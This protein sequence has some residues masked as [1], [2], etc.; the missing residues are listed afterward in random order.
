ME[1]IYT[2][3]GGNADLLLVNMVVHKVNT[4]PYGVK[5]ILNCVARI[6]LPVWIADRSTS[7]VGTRAHLGS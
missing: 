5:D 6:C 3:C 7:P 4:G 2:L 1:H